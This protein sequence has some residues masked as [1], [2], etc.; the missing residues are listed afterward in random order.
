MP[1]SRGV[2]SHFKTGSTNIR[3]GR[4]ADTDA[5]KSIPREVIRTAY[6]RITSPEHSFYF[7]ACLVSTYAANSS[8][9]SGSTAGGPRIALQVKGIHYNLLCKVVYML[10]AEQHPGS[11]YDTASH[12]CGNALCL[13]HCVWEP[14]AVNI[15]RE[16]C[17]TTTTVASAETTF[18]PH[19][20]PC[21][22]RPDMSAVRVAIEKHRAVHMWNL[23]FFLIWSVNEEYI[24][25]SLFI[26]C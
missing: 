13:N 17:H 23:L 22:A 10:H 4:R 19:T 8:T 1:K 24:Y 9:T 20:P 16:I 14:M 12:L 6:S 3:G 11:A 2:K 5:Y 26:R 15:S 25:L 18:C 7:D 21:I